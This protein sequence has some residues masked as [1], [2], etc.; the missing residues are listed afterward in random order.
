MNF[1]RCGQSC[2]STSR[3]FVHERIYAQVLARLRHSLNRYKPGLPTD[4]RTT[5]GAIVSQKQYERVLGYI[6]AGL[7]EGARLI[8]GGKR[9]GDPVLVNGFFVEP[10]VF[11]DVTMDMRIGREEIF[12]PILSI[13]KWSQE[14]AMLEQVNAVEYGLTCA[15]WTNDLGT[16]HRV[17]AEVEAG[18]VWINEVVPALSRRAVR[19]LQAVRY[20]P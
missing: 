4:P 6:D 15:I 12:G 17:A 11:A 19:R 9:S 2:G 8:A 16:A 3:A 18:D 1:G 5:M 7:H 10:T 14:A 20:R 13:F